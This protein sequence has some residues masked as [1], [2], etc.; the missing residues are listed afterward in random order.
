MGG[1]RH[2]Q[3]RLALYRTGNYKMEASDHSACDTKFLGEQDGREQAQAI[4]EE[5]ALRKRGG[6]KVYSWDNLAP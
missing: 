5:L 1:D 2:R 3:E 6:A 4:R